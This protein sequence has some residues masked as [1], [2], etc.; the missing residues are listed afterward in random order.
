M[1][2]KEIKDMMD[3]FQE[4]NAQFKEKFEHQDKEKEAIL[5]ENDMLKQKINEMT[6][7]LT[8]RMNQD[9][10]IHLENKLFDAQTEIEN[11]T[12]IIK[13]MQKNSFNQLIS[14]SGGKLGLES[15]S[16]IQRGANE[17]SRR[18]N[19]PPRIKE[20]SDFNVR[21]KIRFSF[22]SFF[23]IRNQQRLRINCLGK[24]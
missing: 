15:P 14:G 7:D 13:D 22:F 6:E 5:N 23:F 16:P 10:T 20:F 24:F 12:H 11:L 2:T 17:T 1:K 8:I 21:K 3:D 19:S 9:G 4:T 18:Q